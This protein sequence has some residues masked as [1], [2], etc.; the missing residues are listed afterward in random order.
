MIRLKIYNQIQMWFS[1]VLCKMFLQFLLLLPFFGNKNGAIHV[2]I[3]L[4]WKISGE[5]SWPNN[6]DD[7]D[8]DNNTNRSLKKMSC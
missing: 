7:D 2:A 5:I 1:F 3:V 6:D 8:A 4:L